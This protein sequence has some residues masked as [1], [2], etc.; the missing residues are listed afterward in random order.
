MFS[1][2]GQV[3]SFEDK[4]GLS[5]PV[6]RQV[7]EAVLEHGDMRDRDQI[8]EI[9]TGTGVIGRWLANSAWNYVGID[10][11]ESMLATF[12]GCI[13]VPS[14]NAALVCQDG[15]A[16]WPLESGSTRVVFGSRVFHLL[17][18]THVAGE[19]L[20]VAHPGGA[21]FFMG[22]LKRK[23]DTIKSLFRKK[24]RDLLA[25]HGLEH[26][27]NEKRRQGLLELLQAQGGES[28][29]PIRAATWEINL[30]PI[31]AIISW[32]EKDSITKVMPSSEVKEE[33]IAELTQ[34]AKQQFGDLE[35]VISMEQQFMLEGIRFSN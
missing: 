32:K 10:T 24:V 3:K 17:D 23:K 21:T 28:M 33:V 18:A 11:S 19:M 8:F 14:S 29:E 34:W 16:P 20:R 1:S 4:A 26:R 27:P 2:A 13:E 9:G 35:K 7:A 22:T 12:R 30:R 5:D 31:D 15:N 6:A 25:E